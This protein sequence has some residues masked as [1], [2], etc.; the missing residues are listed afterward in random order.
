MTSPPVH[1]VRPSDVSPGPRRP[2]VPQR[3]DRLAERRDR[4]AHR[5]EV[6]GPVNISLWLPTTVIFALLAPFVMLL[7]PFLYLTPRNILPH[8]AR[9]IAG[10]GALLLALGGTVIDIDCPECRVHIRLF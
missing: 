8:P 5:R 7:T 4:R 1:I 2:S 10:V 6:S 9:T 3:R